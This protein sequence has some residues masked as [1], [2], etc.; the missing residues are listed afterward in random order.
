MQEV[1]NPSAIMLSG[2]QKGIPGSCIYCALEGTR[3]VLI[4]VEALV[5]ETSFGTPRRMTTGADYNRVSLIIAVLEKKV[6]LKMYN[7]DI[8]VNVGEVCA[9]GI[10]LWICQLQQVLFLVF[11][12]VQSARELSYLG[13]LA[14]TGEIRHI[15]QAE[16]KNCRSRK[17]GYAK[18]NSSFK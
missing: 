4:E 10:L 18:S 2:R 11:V 16:K 14:L 15:S 9:Y 12:T 8:F 17:N 6:G 1:K 7:Q 3:P 5:S 13:K